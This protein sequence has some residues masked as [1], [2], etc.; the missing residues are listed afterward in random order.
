MKRW[1]DVDR[2]LYLCHTDSSIEIMSVEEF[3]KRNVTEVV[4]HCTFLWALEFLVNLC[5]EHPEFLSK[6]LSDFLVSFKESVKHH[7][8]FLQLK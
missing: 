6:V 8:M 4:E 5:E 3:E 7:S 2:Q 1:I